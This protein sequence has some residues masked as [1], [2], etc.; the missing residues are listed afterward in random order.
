MHASCLSGTSSLTGAADTAKPRTGH[1]NGYPGRAFPAGVAR[2][3]LGSAAKPEREYDMPADPAPISVLFEPLRI[4]GLE[5]AGRMYKAATAET[6]STEDGDV[7]D[8]LLEF[9]EPMA[10]AGT[11]MIITGNMFVA[12]QGKGHDRQT[13]IESDRRI[14][15]LRT[16]ADMTHRHG[17]RIFAQ[18]N[19]CGRQQAAP[20]P[21]FTEAVSA[22]SVREPLLGT[23]ARPMTVDEI[24]RTVHDY[25][26]AAVRA[27]EAGFDGVQLH[28]S[29]G[30]LLSQF[31]TPHTNRRTDEYGGSFDGRLRMPLQVLRTVRAAVGDDFPVIAKLNGHDHLPGRA[32]LDTPAL[33]AIARR[34]QDEGLDAVEISAGHY[35]SGL[36]AERGRFKGVLRMMLTEGNFRKIA[37]WR[38]FMARAAAPVLEAAMARMW[39]PQEG[40]NLP[41]AE[42]F[43]K[44]L[45]IPVICLGGFSSGP[46]MA[47][48]IH[49][50]RC[51][52][53][54]AARA[55]IANPLL[56][57]TLREGV[58]GPRCAWYNGCLAKW[59]GKP[60]DCYH[61]EIRR[62]RD[63]LLA[64]HGL[65]LH[66]RASTEE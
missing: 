27:Q 52:A 31:L 48:A 11:P 46:A 50:G 33:V 21:G 15:G 6:R 54:S 55:M 16:L 4:G 38:R 3:A 47:E 62:Q 63:D 51:D 65:T 9:Y 59:G 39:P 41:Q 32:G 12:P 25:A 29:H 28:M 30:Y 64:K 35:E 1:P 44:E 34:L 60:V 56:Y 57:R 58:E 66:V 45:S 26:A 8:E 43:T 19:H 23:K 36:V 61:P 40:F 22:S 5:L 10:Q 13:G 18:L 53:V 14:P 20:A 17:S 24:H 49:S 42:Q 2:G 37:P 7:T